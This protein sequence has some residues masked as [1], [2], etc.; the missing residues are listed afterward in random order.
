MSI[1]EEYGAFQ[2]V[3]PLLL[4]FN[5]L[6]WNH[7]AMALTLLFVISRNKAPSHKPLQK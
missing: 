3:T 2:N 6:L 1:F 5:N 4:F 7:L